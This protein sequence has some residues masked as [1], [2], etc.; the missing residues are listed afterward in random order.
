M[1]SYNMCPK[2][3]SKDVFLFR[4]I[5]IMGHQLLFA[6]FKCRSCGEQWKS[7]GTQSNLKFQPTEPKDVEQYQ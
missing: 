5:A 2:C 3:F 7:R 6:V 4:H 1:H